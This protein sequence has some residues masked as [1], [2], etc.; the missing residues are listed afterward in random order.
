M[1]YRRT[2]LHF[3]VK[4]TKSMTQVM[5]NYKWFSTMFSDVARVRERFKVHQSKI[6]QLNLKSFQ[7]FLLFGGLQMHLIWFAETTGYSVCSVCTIALY[8]LVNILLKTLLHCNI[9]LIDNSLEF[10]VKRIYLWF[11]RQL[12][13]IFLCNNILIVPLQYVLHYFKNPKCYIITECKFSS[14]EPG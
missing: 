7:N 1:K 8:T 13:A 3:M 6:E 14:Q 5:L 2:F 9:N 11:I 12:E 4:H 10:R